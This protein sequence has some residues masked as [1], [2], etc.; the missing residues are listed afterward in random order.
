MAARK[1]DD[2]YMPSGPPMSPLTKSFF[3]CWAFFDACVGLAEETFGTTAMAV[4]SAL[5]MHSELV[6][7]IGLMQDSRMSGRT[8]ANASR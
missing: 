3:T 1:A 8:E 7:V 2:D 6:R 5:G 4:G